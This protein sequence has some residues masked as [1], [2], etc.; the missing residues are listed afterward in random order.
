MGR[1]AFDRLPEQARHLRSTSPGLVHQVTIGI[2]E[3]WDMP[4][5]LWRA[6]ELVDIRYPENAHRTLSF[7][8]D[9]GWSERLDGLSRG[10]RASAEPDRFMLYP[11]GGARRYAYA[12]GVRVCQ[13]YF[14]G[15]LL[16]DLAAAEGSGAGPE[17]R[18]DRVLASDPLLRRLA[19]DYLAR[20]LDRAQP[21]PALEMD[22]RGVLLGLHLLRRHAARPLPDRVPPGMLYP[23]RLRVALE[24]I[25]AHLAEGAPLA[26][27]ARAVQ[28]SPHHFCTAF[29][30]TVGLSPHAF[31]R[32]R[33]LERARALLEGPLPL[34]EV[35]LSCGFASQQHFTTAFSRAFGISPGA[36]RRARRR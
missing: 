1:H 30:H 15:D 18:D 34:V 28:L 10:R 23:A 27:I 14:R 9:G 29:R 25:D 31:L 3:A 20:A 8:V 19:D 6:G 36:W 32:R 4:L 16:A 7:I 33:R 35:A 17:L 12:A 13:I 2:A 22:A 24:F 11:G 26:A 5:G 21:A